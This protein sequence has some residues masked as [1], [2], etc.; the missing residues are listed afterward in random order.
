MNLTDISARDWGDLHTLPDGPGEKMER[1]VVVVVIFLIC[2]GVYSMPVE[3][4]F[5]LYTNMFYMTFRIN[6]SDKNENEEVKWIIGLEN[7]LISYKYI[8]PCKGIYS[9]INVYTN[10]HIGGNCPL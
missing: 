8:V 7:I 2:N 10:T 3:G 9:V 4:K 6:I 5:T 1:A